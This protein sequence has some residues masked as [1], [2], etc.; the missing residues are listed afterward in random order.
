MSFNIRGFSRR[1]DGRNGWGN[2]AAL[3]LAT[4]ERYVP[5]L[6][7]LQELRPE[8]P[9]YPT[10]SI[11]PGT[12]TSCGRGRAARHPKLQGEDGLPVVRT[13]PRPGGEAERR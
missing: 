10:Q 8:S 6:I 5:G 2:R 9:A 13:R 3:K 1:V 7:G 11:Y 12:P 4:I